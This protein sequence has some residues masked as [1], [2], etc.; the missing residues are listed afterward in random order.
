MRE[1]SEIIAIVT[2]DQNGGFD[3]NVEKERAQKEEVE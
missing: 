2:L 3:M 1:R